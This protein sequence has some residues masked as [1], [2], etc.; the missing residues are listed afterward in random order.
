[1]TFDEITSAFQV[2]HGYDVLEFVSDEEVIDR[3][4][5]LRK[6]SKNT[7]STILPPT[8][9]VKMPMRSSI[10][11]VIRGLGQVKIFRHYYI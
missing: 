7:L 11:K 6:G 3:T 1:M 2:D 9:L 4:A 10:L 5:E 8:L